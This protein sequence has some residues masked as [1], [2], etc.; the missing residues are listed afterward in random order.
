MF[1]FISAVTETVD[2]KDYVLAAE[3]GLLTRNVKIVGQ[4]YADQA[5][6]AFG[7][8]VLVGQAIDIED[9][10]I[11][12][13]EMTLIQT[14]SFYCCLDCPCYPVNATQMGQAS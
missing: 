5:E 7:V 10:Q 2:G 4:E 13:G 6:Q 8:R 11:R 9:E 3:V 12:T 14:A 1:H